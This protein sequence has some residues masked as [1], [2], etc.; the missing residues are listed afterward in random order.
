MAGARA[1]ATAR[2]IFRCLIETVNK[3]QGLCVS[4]RAEWRKRLRDAESNAALAAKGYKTMS[5]PPSYTIWVR[6]HVEE[7]RKQVEA[8]ERLLRLLEG[9]RRW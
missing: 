1:E 3:I 7:F 8:L 4:A 5:E 9:C 6:P 2:D